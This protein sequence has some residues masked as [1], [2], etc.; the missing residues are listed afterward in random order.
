MNTLRK[1]FVIGLTVIGLS[2][3]FAAQAQDVA[4]PHHREYAATKFDPA[5]RAEHFAQRQQ[6]LHDALKLTAAQETAWNAYIAAI[7]PQT[8]VGRADRTD[9]KSLPAPERMEKRLERHKEHLAKQESH[10]AALKTFYAVL[11]PEQQKV[12]DQATVHQG[13]HH[14]MHR[15]AHKQQG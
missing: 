8:P 11:T 2:S 12:F 14:G 9:F 1:S 7:K 15:A 3:A 5:K 13:R 4:A 10:L 6:K